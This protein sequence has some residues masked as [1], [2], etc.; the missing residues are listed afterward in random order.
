MPYTYD[1]RIEALAVPLVGHLMKDEP[2]LLS[3]GLSPQTGAGD[4]A[5]IL[6]TYT[7]GC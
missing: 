2:L 1:T 7:L 3:P 6:T 4:P 5:R